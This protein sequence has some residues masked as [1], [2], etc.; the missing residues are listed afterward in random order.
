MTSGESEGDPGALR[1]PGPCISLRAGVPSVSA[2]GLQVTSSHSSPVMLKGLF[3]YEFL[4]RLFLREGR[5]GLNLFPGQTLSPQNNITN[6]LCPW[7][8]GFK[9]NQSGKVSLILVFSNRMR[10]WFLSFGPLSTLP[11]FSL[12][13]WLRKTLTLSSMYTQ[14]AWTA[15]MGWL[16]TLRLEVTHLQT[17]P[18][19]AMAAVITKTPKALPRGQALYWPIQSTYKLDEAVTAILI[20]QLRKLSFGEVKSWD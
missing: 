6:H 4:M 2:P 1:Y 7:Q 8:G 19:I 13:S 14:V 17:R 12:S 11:C 9:K 18:R 5:R 16:T 20:L 3:C 10:L 15:Q